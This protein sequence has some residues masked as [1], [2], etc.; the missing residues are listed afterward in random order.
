MFEMEF[1]DDILTLTL[2]DFLAAEWRNE[3][4]DMAAY[5]FFGI[6][7]LDYQSPNNL[8]ILRSVANKLPPGSAPRIALDSRIAAI[9]ASYRS[10]K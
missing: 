2:V 9:V 1:S 3:G 4:N 6:G 10:W 7:L 8:E 5:I